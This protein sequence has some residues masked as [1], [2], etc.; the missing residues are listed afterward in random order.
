MSVVEARTLPE[1]RHRVHWWKEAL[2]VVAFYLLYSWTRNRFGSNAVEPGGIPLH[3]FHNA[4]HVIRFERLVG[5]YHEVSIQELFLPYRSFIQFWNTYYGTAHFIVTLAVFA[6]LFWKRPGVFPVWRN[7]LAIMTGLAIVGFALFPLMPPR[8]LDE[9][10]NEYGGQCIES[11]LRGTSGTFGYVD[12]L[13]EY[14]GPWSFDSDTMQD[15]SNQYAA[16][17]S[18]HIGWS[19]WCAVAMWPLLRRRWQR[20]VVFLYPLA[21]LFCIIVTAN[22]FWIDGLGGLACFAVGT[23][24]GWGLHRW[25]QRRLDR[26]YLAALGVAEH[27][28]TG[29][30]PAA[31]S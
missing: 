10:C 1:R 14:G 9:P 11:D 19:T 7:S 21:T 3:S 25:N 13:A 6:L 24:A 22:H 26:K 17:P 12:T 5:L 16:M 27:A 31:G 15:I 29:S 8:L 23:L 2:I 30:V 20:A 28:T 18:M 4:E